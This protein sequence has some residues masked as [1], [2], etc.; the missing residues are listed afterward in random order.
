VKKK[1]IFCGA[2]F[3]FHYAVSFWLAGVWD[4]L[5]NLAVFLSVYLETYLS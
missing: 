2:F 3:L 4:A 1:K 5:L